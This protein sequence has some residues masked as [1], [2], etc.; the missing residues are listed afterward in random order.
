MCLYPKLLRNR[1][2]IATKK[3]KGNVPIL[4]DWRK[5]YVPVGCGMCVECRRQKAR[6]WQVRLNEELK[7]NKNALFVTLSFSPE[8]LEKLCKTYNLEEC[9]AA[10]GKAIRLWLERIRK[11]TGKS[12]KHWLI[13]ELGENNTER[14]HLHGIIFTNDKTLLD[15]WQYGNIYIGEYCSQRTINYVVKYV[16]KLDTLHKNYRPQIFCSPGL[17]RGYIK[18]FT[19]EM[20]QYKPRQT[21]EYYQLNNGTRVNLPI[22]YRN[23]F[24]T[25]EERGNLWTEKLDEDTRYVLGQ[26]ITKATGKNEDLF[27]RVLKTAQENNKRM[28]YGDNSEEWKQETYNITLNML[29]KQKKIPKNLHE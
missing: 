28:G 25:E 1:H 4:D 23:H 17:G 20:H 3:N 19:Q 18:E 10:A 21:R 7:V 5:K 26:K 29:K 2:Y 13:T 27:W 11:K 22:Y 16:L 9:N 8:C 14:I 12:V 6:A 24:F 15:L